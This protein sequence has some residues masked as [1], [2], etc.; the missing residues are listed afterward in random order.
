VSRFRTSVPRT[1][2]RVVKSFRKPIELPQH[3]TPAPT[4]DKKRK[5]SQALRAT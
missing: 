2:I 4:I 1:T 3:Q 5:K